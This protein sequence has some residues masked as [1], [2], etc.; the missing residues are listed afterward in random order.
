MVLNPS[1]FKANNL[2]LEKESYFMS[3][4]QG[5]LSKKKKKEI[6]RFCA[7]LVPS[8]AQQGCRGISWAG[9][10]RAARAV[11]GRWNTRQFPAF[12]AGGWSSLTLLQAEECGDAAQPCSGRVHVAACL[13]CLL[14]P[15]A[16]F[17]VLHCSFTKPNQ[18]FYFHCLLRF[19]G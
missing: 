16:I 2:S 12:L 1:F 10:E 9:L 18:Q 15:V 3:V 4:V 5:Y 6:I 11:G 7:A 14:F 8:V 13:H 19:L 17:L